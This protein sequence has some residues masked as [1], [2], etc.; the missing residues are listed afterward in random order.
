VIAKDAKVQVDFNPD[1]VSHY[2]LIGYEN[3]AI[4][5]QDFRNDAVDAGEIGAGISATALYVVDVRPN[6]AGRMATV[7]LR[8]KDPDGE[9]AHEINGNVNTWDLAASFEEAAPRFQLAVAAGEYAEILRQSPYTSWSNLDS[10]AHCT[11]RL[12]ETLSDDPDVVEFAGLVERASQ[13]GE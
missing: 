1:V 9:Q 8:W 5:D 13:I 12:A 3:R 6:T 10:L 11:R 7:Q 4:A 2:R